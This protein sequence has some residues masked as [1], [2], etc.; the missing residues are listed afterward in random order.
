VALDVR[1]VRH[2]S[3]WLDIYLLART[4]GVVVRGD[5]AY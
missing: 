3:V 1:Y 2:W 5:G 4:L